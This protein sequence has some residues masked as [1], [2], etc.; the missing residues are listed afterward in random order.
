MRYRNV[1][2]LL[3]WLIC[4]TVPSAAFAA[5]ER[6][7]EVYPPHVEVEVPA[8][9]G[10]GT[11]FPCV[12]KAQ[13]LSSVT[14]TFLKRTVTASADKTGTATVLLPVPLDHASGDATLTWKASFT[15]APGTHSMPGNGTKTVKI[16]KKIYPAQRLTLESKYVTPDPEL[17]DRIAAE[18]KQL[19]AALTTK[20]QVR[21]WTLPMQ[22]PVAGKVTSW[23]GLRRI[24]NGEPRSPHKG[25]DFRGATG[26]PIGCIADGTVVLTGDFYYPGMFA[27]VDHGLGVTSIYMHMSE[28]SAVQG[29]KILAGDT[30]GLVGSTG[31]STGPHLHLGITVL[32]HSIDAF[33]LLSMTAADK[34]AYAKAFSDA[35]KEEQAGMNKPAKKKPAA[36]KA[37]KKTT[38]PKTAKPAKKTQ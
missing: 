10:D 11:A 18:R 31:R 23:Y 26:T 16:R 19:N 17:K 13:S 37:T 15:S 20:S 38:A 34:E 22:R 5:E 32:G 8:T 3:F 33:P 27:V 14:V 25:L 30:V 6:S 28:I 9:V 21:H 24:L 35:A 1:I 29:Q 36:T 2:P 4:C 12:I 7:R